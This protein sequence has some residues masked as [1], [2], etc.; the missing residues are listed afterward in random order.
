MGWKEFEEAALDEGLNRRKRNEYEHLR[1]R[2]DQICREILK[3]LSDT[4]LDQIY[5]V[6]AS[7][8]EK[9]LHNGLN[10]SQFMMSELF[11]N[12]C[13]NY[14]NNNTNNN[15]NNNNHNHN[16]NHNHNNNKKNK[17]PHP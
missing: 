1:L 17:N 8:G 6:H 16:H 15:N 5:F 11:R 10:K 7:D 4:G 12:H 3:G 9:N 13:K 14:N 2:Q